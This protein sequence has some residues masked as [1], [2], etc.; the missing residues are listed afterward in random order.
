M[1]WL[2]E[3]KALSAHIEGILEASRFYMESNRTSLKDSY[4][5]ARKQLVPQIK[6]LMKD[7]TNFRDSHARFIPSQA[8][9][10]L[11]DQLEN[12]RLNYG[13]N[14]AIGNAFAFVHIMG[15]VLASFRAGFDYYISDTAAV[16][17]RL[18]ERA[19]LH[20]RR[21]IVADKDQRHKWSNAFSLG[22]PEC[23]KLGARIC[24]CMESGRLKSMLKANGRISSSMNLFRICL[25]LHDRLKV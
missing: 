8:A 11:D 13:E 1:N 4:E 2:T 6:T 18:S 12:V 7:L 17:R 22:E 24:C 20:L 25:K 10:F 23:E 15:T 5:V 21:S 14:L 9:Q 16:A 3:W 19:F